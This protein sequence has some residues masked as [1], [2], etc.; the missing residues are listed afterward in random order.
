MICNLIGIHAVSEISVAQGRIDMVLQSNTTF[1]IFEF[2]LNKTAQEALEQ[3]K[4][5]R[6]YEKYLHQRR[7]VYLV[8]MNFDYKKKALSYVSERLAR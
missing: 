1:Y 6:Y 2:K 3:I 7:D 4:E 5:K 8:G